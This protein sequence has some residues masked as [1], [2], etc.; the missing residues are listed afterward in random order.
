MNSTVKI[1]IFITI[2]IAVIVSLIFFLKKEKSNFQL[3]NTC[4]NK[5]NIKNIFDEI[6]SKNIWTKEG[7]GSGSGSSI[8]N[9]VNFRNILL[10]FIIENDINILIDL[11]CG[12]CLW[13]S[14]FLN[15]LKN[16]NKQITYYGVDIA[17]NAVNNCKKSVNELSNFHNI[18]I[19]LDNISTTNIPHNDLLLSRDTLQHLSFNDIFL[20]LKNFA[21]SDSKWYMIG[22]YYE[23][24]ENI[25]INN[26]DYFD[27]NITLYPFF[28]IPDKIIKE[29]NKGDEKSKYLFIFNGNNF[30]NQIQNNY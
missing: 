5:S 14:V 15:E 26:G 23:S 8:E 30:R 4:K 25:N 19:K 21:K 16:N 27:F 22:G 18:N 12:S 3:L 24:N 17:D 6:Y 9:T 20:T 7:G 13:T 28:L 1:F 2:I 29:N 11:P 10:K